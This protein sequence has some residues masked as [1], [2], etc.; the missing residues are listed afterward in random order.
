MNELLLF[1][2]VLSL[3]A[4]SCSHDCLMITQS[5]FSL[6]IVRTSAVKTRRDREANPKVPPLA[7]SAAIPLS[8]SVACGEGQL[9]Q[10]LSYS[11]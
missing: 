11:K 4:S 8:F 9:V 2:R 7:D 10:E 5:D 3:D 6:S 1:Q